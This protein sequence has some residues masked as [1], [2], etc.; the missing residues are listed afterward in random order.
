MCVSAWWC[1]EY[2]AIMLVSMSLI[3]VCLIASSLYVIRRHQLNKQR[4][5]R[6]AVSAEYAFA[7]ASV[8]YTAATSADSGAMHAGTSAPP[9]D[10]YQQQLAA[11]LQVISAVT[12]FSS[13]TVDIRS[14]SGVVVTR[15]SP[16]TKLLLRR[17]RL[18]LGWVTVSGC[19][20]RCRTFISVC[21]Q[22]PR[23]TQPGHLF[24][25][26]CSEYQPKGGDVL[27]LGSKG[28]YGSCVCGWQ[29]KL[30][31]P[32]FTHGPY[33]SAL[34]IHVGHYKTLYKFTFFNFFYNL[35]WCSARQLIRVW[36]WR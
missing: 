12:L 14:W 35:T 24:V 25:D 8:Q 20:S 18:V 6:S 31:D 10:W 4:H 27:R 36:Q 28:R 32:I 13:S 9:G 34:E 29:V 11:L 19:N 23:Q 26:R 1:G 16:S 15:W 22:P 3:I 7:A 30:C 2:C 33:Q 17:A 21:N 5:R